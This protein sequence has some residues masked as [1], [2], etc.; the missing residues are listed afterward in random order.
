MKILQSNLGRKRTAMD[1][2]NAISLEH[3]IDL[4]IIA[5]PNKKFVNKS[6]WYVD[7]KSDAAIRIFNRN[8]KCY[9]SSTSQDG[10]AWVELDSMVVY[11][12][13]ISPNIDLADF[14]A[15]L[16]KL[17]Q[18]FKLHNKPLLI[19][20]DFNAKSISWGNQ[21]TDKRGD[22]LKEWMAANDL[23]LHNNDLKPTFVGT[24]GESFIDLT[25]TS[26]RIANITK[27]WHVSE[28]ENLSCHRNILYEITTNT[29][30]DLN[31]LRQGWKIDEKSLEQ[32][33]NNLKPKLVKLQAEQ[34][35]DPTKM[36]E[37]VFQI[38]NKTLRKKKQ[39]S[40][41]R[42]VYWWNPEVAEIR[43]E[44]LNA[45]RK[46]TRGNKKKNLTSTD[47][48]QLMQEYRDKRQKLSN[49]IIH[50]K[51]QSWKIVCDDLNNNPWG[52][53]YKLVQKKF[54]IQNSAHLDDP[55][56]EKTI[57]ELF[58]SDDVSETPTRVTSTVNFQMFTIDELKNATNKIKNGKAAGPDGL[59]PEIA[60]KAVLCN[61]EYFLRM[62]N[63]LFERGMFPSEWKIAR[64]VLLEKP[65]DDDTN[66]KFRPLCLLD[67]FGKVLEQLIAGRMNEHL[68]S[69]QCLWQHQYGFR[70]KRSTI[71]AITA[72]TN[73]IKEN[74]K[75]ASK[76]RKYYVL[77]T[78]DIKN[79]FNSLRWGVIRKA[80]EDTG[81][82]E[83]VQNIIASYLNNRW[84]IADNGL[85]YRVTCGVPQGSVLG[86]I[87]W[88]VAY[89]GVLTTQLPGQAKIV[90][91][92]DDTAIL[93]AD[94]SIE[95]AVEYSGYAL[96]ILSE[97]IKDIHLTLATHKTEMVILYGGN[98]HKEIKIKFND[99]M[100]ASKNSIRYLGLIMSQNLNWKDQIT[101]AINKA[102]KI[103]WSLTRLMPATNGP[104]TS[105]RRLI[106]TA[107]MSV[108]LYGAPVWGHF[109]KYAVYC[110]KLERVQ[111]QMLLRISCA[112]RTASTEAIQ[113]ISGVAP[114]ELTIQE[115]KEIY[116]NP[117]ERTE[118]K[119]QTIKKW[120]EKWSKKTGKAE[121]TKQLIKDIEIWLHRGHG[122]VDY[123]LSQFLTGH[124]EFNEYLERFKLKDNKLCSNCNQTDSA[125]H[126]FFECSRWTQERNTL[127]CS[128]KVN[129]TVDNVIKTMCEN[130]EKWDKI[131]GYIKTII[132]RKESESRKTNDKKK[133]D[134]PM[135]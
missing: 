87:L 57:T 130:L 3:N 127:L 12:C 125:R 65:G 119:T 126:M 52:D 16:C 81:V 89:N 106:C 120:Q 61:L 123:Y 74:R 133:G 70:K 118:I 13:Y 115:R 32:F 76:N 92:A 37:K 98:K 38:C 59:A 112:Y 90:G 129:L 124:G 96:E 44:A 15:F 9:K 30:N 67:C 43:R 111:R 107:A 72:I 58:P 10:F 86:P 4:V 64:M 14:N 71:N 29:G 122:E 51:Q 40:M 34:N 78:V 24:Q 17:E 49:A 53:G 113:V 36:L 35:Y 20:G 48:E 60:K 42:P 23:V 33:A 102:E 121:W 25:M 104:K 82:D 88:N 66:K 83:Y 99:V 69:M 117:G 131:S 75:L 41:R 108:M 73:E 47:K 2:L 50:A 134:M 109:V 22:D 55:T 26:N 128:V 105:V 31:H 135:Q 110:K 8:I 11:S 63:R 21:Y 84:I 95:N 7:R 97:K 6:P 1:L 18:D 77:V 116:E 27:G 93:I 91:Y 79:A 132:R 5:E 100:V 114:I 85:K 80:V 103:V 54:K 28:D 45:K 101:N 19:G 39:N 46:L 56:L 62:Y 68:E 94:K